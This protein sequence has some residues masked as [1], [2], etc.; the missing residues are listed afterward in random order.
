MAT[1]S[2]GSVADTIYPDLDNEVSRTRRMLELFPAE[3]NDWQPHARS[4]SLAKLASHVA[5]LP[6]FAMAIVTTDCMDFMKGEYVSHSCNSKAEILDLFD[7][8]VE[9][10]RT[11]LQSAD[12]A[13]LAR[14]WTLRRGEQVLG[15]GPK[16]VLVRDFAINHMVHHRAQLGVY[17]RLLDLPIPGL[18]GPSADEKH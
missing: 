16:G 2:F 15:T 9:S 10:L 6:R 11:A 4:M 12:A 1:S 13:S 3:H 18:Y 7:S 5:E 14:P 8:S 17:Y